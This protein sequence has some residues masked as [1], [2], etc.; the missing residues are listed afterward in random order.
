[1]GSSSRSLRPLLCFHLLVFKIKI[2]QLEKSDGLR[3][4]MGLGDS[5]R[6]EPE[7]LCVSLL[8]GQLVGS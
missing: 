1:M 7:S 5:L 8:L 2:R 6:V 4:C 3:R